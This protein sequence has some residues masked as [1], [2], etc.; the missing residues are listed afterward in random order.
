M[1]RI[2]RK[3]AFTLIEL[4]VVIAIIAILAA[5][6]VPAVSSALDRARSTACMSNQRQVG[7]G[8]IGYSLDNEGAIPVWFDDQKGQWAGLV[9][10]Y[11]GEEWVDAFTSDTPPSGRR[12]FFCP[13]A[14]AEAGGNIDDAAHGSF[15][16]NASFASQPDVPRAMSGLGS[17][18]LTIA[19][20][21]GHFLEQ[22]WW[23]AG[24]FRST[25]GNSAGSA[26][27]PDAVHNGSANFT[28]ADGHVGSLELAD[29][30]SSDPADKKRW[31][32]WNTNL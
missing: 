12:V 9:G 20:A 19:L 32:P 6:L 25:L 5:I 3:Q 14:W 30:T 11:M 24:V 2:N 1:K 17:P 16:M 27:T 23:M 8:L 28:Y 15:G 18:T 21:D 4:L 29:Y 7:I 31:E 13:V 10:P 26:G 22:G